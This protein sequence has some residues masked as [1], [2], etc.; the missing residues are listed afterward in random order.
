MATEGIDP[1]KILEVRK[2]FTL[3]ELKE[4][5]KKIAL[6]VH[7][8]KGG[9]EYM[10]NLVTS[11]FKELMREYKRRISDV[12]HNELKAAFTKYSSQN[13]QHESQSSFKGPDRF[14]LEKFNKLFEENK[15]PDVTDIGYND[16]YKKEEKSKDPAFKGGSREAFNSHFDKYVKP[17][18]ENKHIVKY[19]EPEAL[20]SGKKIQCMD[21]GVQDI[22]DFS[23][24]NTSLKK[25]NFSDLKLAHTTSRIVDPRQASRA[26]YKSIDDLKRDRGNVRFE[27][28]NDEKKDYIRKQQQQQEIEYKRQMFLKHKD[29][30]IER[31]YQR[32][33]NLL[34]QTMK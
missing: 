20:F 34:Q 14:N 32:V 11:C 19:K 26:E 9:N 33:N 8:D 23:G 12:Q 25:L 5:Y 27:M 29:N 10:F 31:H 16:W 22:D 21:L 4:N 3:D 2:N 30:E 7:P 6:R 15:M 17:S 24:D 13:T 18:V 28:N 1:Y